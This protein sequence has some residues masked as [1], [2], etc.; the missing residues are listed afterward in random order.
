MARAGVAEAFDFAGRDLSEDFT[1]D[2]GETLG[3]DFGKVF[4][5]VLG[6]DA[7][8]AMAFKHQREGNG[9]ALQHGFASARK[10]DDPVP[11]RRTSAFACARV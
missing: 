2:F 5:E 8:L 10:P 11:R 1:A 4:S 7:A 6:L 9:R 3:E